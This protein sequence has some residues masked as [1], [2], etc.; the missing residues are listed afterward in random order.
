MRDVDHHYRGGLR[1]EVC[2]ADRQ[3]I[4]LHVE[5]FNAMID[6]C[7]P[8]GLCEIDLLQHVAELELS[9]FGIHFISL[10]RFE[11]VVIA[12]LGFF[13]LAKNFFKT[14]FSNTLFCFWCNFYLTC[15]LVFS[16]VSLVL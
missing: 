13:Q 4:F 9:R 16:D 15:L 7:I 2:F 11:C 8:Y 12:L 14:S 10:T 1:F 5:T 6:L 3:V